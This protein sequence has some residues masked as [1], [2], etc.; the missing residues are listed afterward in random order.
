MKST[1]AH[2]VQ[3]K[4]QQGMMTLRYE[5]EEVNTNDA[6]TPTVRT[7]YSELVDDKVN[8]TY[9]LTH[10]GNMDYAT[11]TR[12]RD[13]K[14]FKFTI[15]HDK[16]GEDGNYRTS[17]CFA[18]PEEEEAVDIEDNVTDYFICYEGDE[19]S[20]LAISINF[21]KAGRALGVMYR[22]QTDLMRL[23]FVSETMET[24][25]SYP[26]TKTTYNELYEGKVNGTYLLTH[27]GNWDYATYTR[28][29]DGAEFTFTIDHD[30]SIDGGGYRINPCYYFEPGHD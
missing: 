30:L 20:G 21:N 27:S 10:A 14:V 2:L 16:L 29:R 8:G 4:G 12:G 26:T 1:E 7:T 18:E 3:Y 17:S 28:G 25:G 5:K 24:K 13:G 22:G 19:E 6:P 15:D 11:Y 9:L 23:A